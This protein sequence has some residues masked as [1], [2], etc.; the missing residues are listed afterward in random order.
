M[1][2]LYIDSLQLLITKNIFFR[3]KVRSGGL[4]PPPLFTYNA[5]DKAAMADDVGG[6]KIWTVEDQHDEEEMTGK[7]CI[8]RKNI[9]FH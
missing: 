7:M 2:L 3:T 5:P 8:Y 1:L 4:S 9:Y 6:G